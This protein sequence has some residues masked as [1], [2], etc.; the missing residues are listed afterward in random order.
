MWKN[1]GFMDKNNQLHAWGFKCA[2]KCSNWLFSDVCKL[3][4]TID[5]CVCSRRTFAYLDQQRGSVL[6]GLAISVPCAGEVIMIPCRVPVYATL[7]IWCT[8]GLLTYAQ[9]N[10]TFGIET[11]LIYVVWWNGAYGIVLLTGGSG[12]CGG[13]ATWS[14]L[15]IKR[16]HMSVYT[17]VTQELNI[18]IGIWSGWWA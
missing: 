5:W 16:M 10:R 13:G 8:L 3:L 6:R 11:L 7:F 4:R 14:I 9:Y 12:E 1:Q 18:D 2:F 15:W 17:P